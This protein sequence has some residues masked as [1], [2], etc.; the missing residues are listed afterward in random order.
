MTL[1]PEDLSLPAQMVVIPKGL[2][3]LVHSV[4]NAVS[5]ILVILETFTLK[6][7]FH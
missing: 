7:A 4:L 5:E 1:D 6:N 3:L 2:A